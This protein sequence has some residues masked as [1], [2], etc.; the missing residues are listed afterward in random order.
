MIPVIHKRIL[1]AKTRTWIGSKAVFNPYAPVTAVDLAAEE[2]RL[3]LTLPPD[4]RDWLL[5]AGYGD[6]NE[7]LSFR[8]DWFWVINRGELVGHVFFAQDELGNFHSISPEG[9]AVHFHRRSD[10]E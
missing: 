6:I 10:P 3:D 7:V 1:M 5:F 8:K 2:E 4:L 9:S